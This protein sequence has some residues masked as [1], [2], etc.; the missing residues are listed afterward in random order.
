MISD[1]SEESWKMPSFG[2]GPAVFA[3]EKH[4]HS[5]CEFEYV[6]Q[7]SDWFVFE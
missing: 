6:G 3:F 2:P 1:I 7:V 4:L 5:F